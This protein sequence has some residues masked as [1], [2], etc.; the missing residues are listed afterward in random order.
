M[1][2]RTINQ[3]QLALESRTVDPYGASFSLNL[4]KHQE[5]TRE[6]KISEP[7]ADSMASRTIHQPQLVHEGRTVEP[8]G[9]SFSL[10][11]AKHQEPT[12]EGKMFDI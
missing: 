12:R 7:T 5:P 4:A 1:A 11:L 3:P 8:Y 9:A 6:G 10:N 2:S